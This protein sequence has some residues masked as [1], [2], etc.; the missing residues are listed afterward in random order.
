MK[1]NTP[2]NT[3]SPETRS[4]GSGA[5]SRQAKRSHDRSE[6]LEIRELLCQVCNA[7]Y[8]VWFAP[9]DLWNRVMRLQGYDKYQFV[10]LNC[11]AKE[12]ESIGIKST[13]W[14]LTMEETAHTPNT[15]AIRQSLI[16]EIRAKMPAHKDHTLSSSRHNSAYKMAQ[17]EIIDQVNLILTEIEG[18]E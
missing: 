11:F 17:N 7:D 9:N 3:K 15:K 1:S 18:G 6:T 2:P 4:T 10:C 12:A 5:S 13:A 14:K 16:A 8:P